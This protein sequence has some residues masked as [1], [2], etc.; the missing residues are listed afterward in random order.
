MRVEAVAV[1][2][3]GGAAGSEEGGRGRAR[4]VAESPCSANLKNTFDRRFEEG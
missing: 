2:N 1:R 3:G 4:A